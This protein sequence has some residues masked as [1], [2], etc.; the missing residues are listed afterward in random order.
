MPLVTTLLTVII[1]S[2]RRDAR[3][4]RLRLADNQEVILYRTNV[5]LETVVVEMIVHS[6]KH[7]HTRYWLVR[8]LTHGVANEIPD[9]II[10][11]LQSTAWLDMAWYYGARSE[12]DISRR[13]TKEAA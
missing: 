12:H 10:L 11:L 3:D 5:I 6:S 4:G 7:L 13:F 8:V 2:D 1:I 9:V